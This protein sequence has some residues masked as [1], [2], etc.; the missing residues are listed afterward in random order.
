MLPAKRLCGLNL[1]S[2]FNSWARSRRAGGRP[3]AAV[4][5]SQLEE[6]CLMSTFKFDGYEWSNEY[7]NNLAGAGWYSSGQ[8]WAPQNATGNA[9][10]LHLELK[11][12]TIKAPGKDYTA[13]SSSEIDLVGKGGR[14][15]NPGFGTYLVAANT[16]GG[17]D[18]LASNETVVFGAFTYQ[19][20]EDNSQINSHRELDMIEASR[21]GTP[22]NGWIGKGTTNGQ[23]TLQPYTHSPGINSLYDNVNVNRFTMENKA[24]ITLTMVW[25]GAN[26]P[27]TFNEYYGVHNLNEVKGL[28]P[29]I[30]WT[31]SGGSDPAAGQNPLIPNSDQQTLHLNLWR[32]PQSPDL[33]A[34][35]KEEVTIKKF[36][37]TTDTNVIPATS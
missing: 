29:N 23:F 17:F 4:G 34:N 15:F 20:N 13:M 35:F 5:V 2:R 1:R 12:A 21:F 7:R 8:Q 37:Y 6:R 36:Q 32:Q 3:T 11:T 24:D 19:K 30:T 25:K 33:P 16:K 31:T 28:T 10:G 14:P 22:P 9:S 27:V 18:K 26:Q